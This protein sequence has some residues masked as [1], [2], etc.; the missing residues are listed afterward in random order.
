MDAAAFAREIE[1]LVRPQTFPLAIKMLSKNDPAPQKAKRPSRDWGIQI[2][3]CQAVSMARRYGWTLIVGREDLNCV[4]TKTV[5]GF[6]KE[7]RYYIEG[8][9][10]CGM[11]TETL[12]AGA[13]TEA[14]TH[15]FSYGEYEAILIAPAA[16]TAFEPDVFLVYAN[17]AQVLRM[18]TG[19]LYRRGGAI[20]SSFTGRLDCSDEIIR[21]MKTKE[22][23]V[24][25]P[26]YGDRVF[27]QTEDHEMAFAL[28]ASLADELIEGL[29]G[30][31][32]GGIRYPIPSFLRYSG[33]FPA[34]YERLEQIWRSGDAE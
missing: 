7:T 12:E 24:I 11:Y 14:E 18:V 3:T 6:E 34:S 21:T 33:Q 10:S 22:Y 16:R 4:L 25:L 28:P 30:T 2:A 17:P 20:H 29:H 5:F 23:Q 1:L 13:K 32:K 19:A 26:C 31:Q 9:C 15:R 27:G 8:H